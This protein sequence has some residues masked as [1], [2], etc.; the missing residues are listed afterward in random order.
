MYKNKNN[1][2]C[3]GRNTSP[4][5]SRRSYIFEAH[6][7]SH[8]TL[9]NSQISTRI[10]MKQ[11]RQSRRGPQREET[12]A[13]STKSSRMEPDPFT[14]PTKSQREEQTSVTDPTFNLHVQG[15]K[16]SASQ[17]SHRETLESYQHDPAGVMTARDDLD[18]D[19]DADGDGDGDGDDDGKNR[20]SPQ[21]S[22]DNTWYLISASSDESS[23]SSRSSAASSPKPTSE[24]SNLSNSSSND[25]AGVVAARVTTRDDV[26]ADGDGDG[27]G[28]G[29]D[30]GKN[31]ESP[32]SSTDNTRYVISARSDESSESSRSSEAS[33]PSP[34]SESSN[35]SNSSSNDALTVVGDE[36]DWVESFDQAPTQH[37]PVG[38]EDQGVQAS[39]GTCR[40][41]GCEC[42]IT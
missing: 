10:T 17:K 2:Q 39:P 19:V 35:L 34:T 22:T 27:D 26:D 13:Q 21:S 31:R 14:M 9:Y 15:Y 25:P 11:R 29:D 41:C 3:R 36:D 18:A 6:Q 24:S 40:R 12:P 30:D 32:Q 16:Q 4:Q 7:K 8:Q 37:D 33:R 23:E 1:A 20:E 5:A 42:I 28:D 38:L